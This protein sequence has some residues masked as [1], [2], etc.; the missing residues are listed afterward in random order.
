MKACLIVDDSKV[1]CM[2]ARKILQEL[3]FETEEAA[4][5]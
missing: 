5:G 1:I 2:V 3:N 4:D